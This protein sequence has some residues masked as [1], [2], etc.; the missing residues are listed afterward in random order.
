MRVGISGSRILLAVLALL[1]GV[2]GA[3]ASEPAASIE[4]AP[5]P[6]VELELIHPPSAKMTGYLLAFDPQTVKL[7]PLDSNEPA[8]VSADSIK[9]MRWLVPET[10]AERP[11][12][13]PGDGTDRPFV[14][15][16]P[17]GGG[18]DLI[19][20]RMQNRPL[21]KGFLESAGALMLTT[22]ERKR[23]RELS[24]K[25]REDTLTL[26]ERNELKDLT[27]KFGHLLVARGEVER[28]ETPEQMEELQQ[29]Y[30]RALATA[31]EEGPAKEH[32]LALMIAYQADE[33]LRPEAIGPMLHE[34]VARVKQP[35]LR[36]ELEE[37][38]R[39]AK[40]LNDQMRRDFEDRK[41]PPP[42]APP[43][44]NVERRPPL[45]PRP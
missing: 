19:G 39:E 7:Q 11:D 5:G 33:R 17:M 36:A 1:A 4:P 6:K 44:Q 13:P 2:G 24:H 42:D 32:L 27:G 41:P 16:P 30:R 3:R 15:R 18:R 20:T 37:I 10:P 45:R 28:A 40:A 26:E 23:V 14:R 35:R 29:R 22:A 25:S 21:I 12:G 43:D 38:L 8:S 31:T 34:D 9:R